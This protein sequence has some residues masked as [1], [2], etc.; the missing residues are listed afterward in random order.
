MRTWTAACVAPVFF[1]EK[2]A[3][4]PG[5]GAAGFGCEGEF[6]VEEGEVAE[7]LSGGFGG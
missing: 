1:L 2:E 7:D 6:E 3:L 5:E 4:E